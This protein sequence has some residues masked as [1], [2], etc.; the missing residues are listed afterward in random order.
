MNNEMSS[1]KEKTKA[2]D[3]IR[4]M[5]KIYKETS[6]HKKW[7][8]GRWFGGIASGVISVFD[9]YIIGSSLDVAL[10]GEYERLISFIYALIAIF[11]IRIL[12]Q[13]TNPLIDSQYELR[14]YR[15]LSMNAYNKIDKLEMGYY[16][17]VHTADTISTLIDDIEKIKTFMGNTIAGFLSWNPVSLIL[18]IIILC[19]INWK[20]TLFSLTIV[21]I[22]MFILNKVSEPLKAAKN[23]IQ[24]HTAV[25]NSYLRDFIEGNDI[26]KAFN[27]HKSHTEKFQ[28][29]CQNIANESYKSSLVMTKNRA[30]QI[31]MMVIPQGICMFASIY[32][33][34]RNELTIG[35]YVI[36]SNM[37]W[38]LI[39]TFRTFGIG[40]AEMIGYSGTAERYFKFLANKEERTDGKDF[41]TNDSD[42]IVEF[43]NVSFSYHDDIP[44]LKDVSFKLYKNS[45]LALCGVSGS[46]KSTIFKLI[47]GYYENF[48]GEI[49]IFGHDIRAWNLNALRKYMTCVTQDVFLFDDSI[50]NNIRMGNLDATDEMI[51]DASKKAYID[52]FIKDVGERGAKVSGGQR[53]RI[54]VAR[55]LLKDAPL[56]MLDEPTSALDTKS[57][58]YVQKS[59]ENLKKGRSVL[60]IAHRL[61]TIIDSDQIILLE[62][63]IIAEQGTHEQLIKSNK[64]YSELYRRQLVDQEV[65]DA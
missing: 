46:G 50:V 60:I 25:L 5:A 47:C 39:H 45:R 26:Y 64:R 16:E 51:E 28:D 2:K 34:A 1:K 65:Q 54:A 33:I 37:L 12:L 7:A 18:S 15:T 8:I 49:Y 21:P 14:T 13:F 27:M 31:L 20:L 59:I 52:Q 35:Q 6:E 48:T 36:F 10:S 55:A 61:T 56:I 42:I 44:L 32:F 63:G 57:E 53:Q 30:L 4:M 17:N 3:V 29:S 58:F 9:F 11:V 62:D 41:G 43:K 19:S 38:P 24:E 23:N 22:V 40:W